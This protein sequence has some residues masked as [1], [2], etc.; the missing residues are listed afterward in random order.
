MLKHAGREKEKENEDA[1]CSVFDRR[2]TAPPNDFLVK[3][4]KICGDN[5]R[6]LIR[7]EI[8]QILHFDHKDRVVEARLTVKRLLMTLSALSSIF[9]R[10]F[11]LV[12][13]PF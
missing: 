10:C 13:C 12:S 9:F 11:K 3:L 6:S 7:T 1:K 2:L 8:R 5:P 4:A